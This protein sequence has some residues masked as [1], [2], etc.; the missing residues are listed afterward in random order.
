MI[1]FVNGKQVTEAEFVLHCG[2]FPTPLRR[3][4]TVISLPYDKWP[5]WAKA[6][7]HAAK[8]Q[9]KGIGDLVARL[10]GDENSEA[11]TK[12]FQSTF[13]KP[14]GCKGRQALWNRVY[15]LK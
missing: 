4:Q 8:P 13:N 5:I 1:C 7:A 6:L 2:E 15:P 10:I 9:D 11:F 3:P 14:C 12:W